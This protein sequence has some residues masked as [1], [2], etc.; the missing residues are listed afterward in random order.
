[1]PFITGP[2]VRPFARTSQQPI[3][4]LESISSADLALSVPFVRITEIDPVTRAPIPGRRPIMF[5]LIEPPQ[6]G[7]SVGAG[8]IER[9]LVS[10]QSVSISTQQNYGF[11]F[12]SNVEIAFTIHRPAA[13]FSSDV[14]T[15]WRSLLR[16]GTSHVL[17]YG[18]IGSSKNQLFNGEGFN[19]ISSGLVVPSIKFMLINVVKYKFSIAA[20]GEMNFI[21]EAIENSE[22]GLRNAKLGDVITR[23]QASVRQQSEAGKTPMTDL[24][25]QERDREITKALAAALDSIPKEKIQGYG[26][27]YRFGDIADRLLAPLIEKAASMMGYAG[28]NLYIGNFNKAAGFTSD[29]YGAIDVADRSIAEFLVPVKQLKNELGNKYRTGKT[30]TFFNFISFVVN[31]MNGNPWRT[32]SPDKLRVP[33]VVNIKTFTQTERDGKLSFNMVIL[34]QHEGSH[35]FDRQDV[36][37]LSDQSR[38]KVL[39][40]VRDKY[41]PIVQYGHAFSFIKDST[42]NVIIDELMRSIFIERTFEERKARVERV[43]KPDPDGRKGQSKPEEFVPLSTIEGEIEMLGNFVFENFATIWIDFF[44]IGQMSGTFNVRNR[45]DSLAPGIFTTTI[46]VI[47]DGAD[48]LNT[49][50]RLSDAELAELEKRRKDQELRA[51]KKDKSR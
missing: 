28:T 4:L 15:S 51:A 16:E 38:E 18:W 3:E 37:A 49:R 14:G 25:D 23:Q 22:L 34:D 6:F 24:P 8:L 29:A 42:F 44:G 7:A 12:F 41:V 1:M 48:P 47:S 13:V 19:D 30:V 10:L 11:S 9:P 20:N 33:P 27:F 17:E 39:Q 2:Q 5:D 36:L 32:P 46:S 21:V 45:R 26:E 31:M 35:P 50:K 43:S 40:R